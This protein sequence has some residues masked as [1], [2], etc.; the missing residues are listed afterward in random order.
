[1]TQEGGPW[2]TSLG[3][4]LLTGG[5]KDA[6]SWWR[7]E[8]QTVAAALATAH[9][10]SSSPVVVT[11]REEQQ[12]EVEL[13]TRAGL[14]AQTTPPGGSHGRLRGCWSSLARGGGARLGG[15]CHGAV[16]LHQSFLAR[17]AEEE[18]AREEAEVRLLEGEEVDKERRLQEELEKVLDSP[19][20]PPWATFSGME[21]A[22]VHWHVAM[23]KAR[24]NEKRRK[25]RK[26]RRRLSCSS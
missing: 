24:K 18:K 11:R 20:H 21:K 14:R 22:A 19:H 4:P 5:Q 2:P 15:R 25:R 1:M 12:E 17:E 16:L 10:H 6:C 3:P 7:H 8:A 9:H 13:E 23:D 26:R